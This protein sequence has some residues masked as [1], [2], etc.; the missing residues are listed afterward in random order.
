MK[1][2]LLA[3]L[4][5]VLLSMSMLLHAQEE[6]V[7]PD[8]Y[9]KNGAVAYDESFGAVY[10]SN[11]QQ[12][13]LKRMKIF[14]YADGRDA[15]E[16]RYKNIYYSDGNVAY[17]NLNKNLYYKNGTMAYNQA[18]RTVYDDKGQVM[19]QLTSAAD[20]HTFTVENMKVTV[21]NF[22]KYEFELEIPDDDFKYTTNLV[23]SF[24]IYEKGTGKL[25]KEIIF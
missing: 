3:L 6:I 4:F 17:N 11:Q 8:L 25:L 10:A 23:N 9:H 15:Y 19:K 14:K 5:S 2:V 12:V 22:V 16:P 18:Q 7:D 24:K 20:T 21:S 13:F 1:K